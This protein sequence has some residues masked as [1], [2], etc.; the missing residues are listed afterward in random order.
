MKVSKSQPPRGWS[1]KYDSDGNIIEYEGPTRKGDG[2]TVRRVFLN[3]KGKERGH[4]VYID[5]D[6]HRAF[7]MAEVLS[8]ISA[9]PKD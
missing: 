9:L 5:V 8:L 2:F 7:S 4:R 6:P 1:A 3:G